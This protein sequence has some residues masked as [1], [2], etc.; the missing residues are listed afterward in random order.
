[1]VPTRDHKVIRQWASRHDAVPA[2]IK[3]FKFDSEPAILTFLLGGA[4]SGTPELRPISWEGFFAQFDLLGLAFAFDERSPQFTLVH[5]EK[6]SDQP[7][8]SYS[9]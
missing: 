9:N 4:K 6:S 5:V 7:G 1:M 3:P 8:P 2:E